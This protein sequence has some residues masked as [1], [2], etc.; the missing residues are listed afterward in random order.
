LLVVDV[1]KFKA[2]AWIVILL[3]PLLVALFWQIRSHYIWTAKKLMSRSEHL[4]S[5]KFKTHHHVAII[6]ISGIHQGVFDALQY[7]KSISKE[8]RACYVD[9]DKEATERLIK[10]WGRRFP[11]ITLEVLKSPYRSV[12]RPVLDYVSTVE[13][14]MHH[15]FV[16]VIIPEFIT[17]RWYHKFMHNQTAIILYAALRSKKNIFVTSVRYHLN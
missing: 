2:G 17:T 5:D 9:I 13:K 6:P 10:D 8:V 1:T 4:I 12:I 11:D 16:T 3:I 15:D 14:S 7:A